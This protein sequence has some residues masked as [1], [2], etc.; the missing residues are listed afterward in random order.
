M[1][2]GGFSKGFSTTFG[3]VGALMLVAVVLSA[4][5]RR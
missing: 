1:S 2:N 4:L 5:N 3:V